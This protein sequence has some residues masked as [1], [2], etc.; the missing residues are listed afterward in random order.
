MYKLDGPR[1][2]HNINVDRLKVANVSIHSIDA[3][4]SKK[5][6]VSFTYA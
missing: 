1:E 4:R 2:I 6:S 5:V 3:G